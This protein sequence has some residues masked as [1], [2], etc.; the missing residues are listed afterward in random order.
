LAIG[1]QN[2]KEERKHLK[3]IRKLTNNYKIDIFLFLSF[4]PSLPHT[5]LLSIN[6]H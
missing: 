5:C 2:V 1:V 3:E 6:H 4:L